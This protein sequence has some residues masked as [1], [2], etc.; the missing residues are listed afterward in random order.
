MLDCNV[1]PDAFCSFVVATATDAEAVTGPAERTEKKRRRPNR[2]AASPQNRA[3]DIAAR[4]V[5]MDRRASFRPLSKFVFLVSLYWFPSED[6]YGSSMNDNASMAMRT[7]TADFI[8]S[9]AVKKI[10]QNGAT[11]IY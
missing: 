4:R 6:I 2:L 7:E 8:T 11:G 3:M 10:V 1:I 9:R 5:V